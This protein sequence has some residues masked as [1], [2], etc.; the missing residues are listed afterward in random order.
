MATGGVASAL[1]GCTD[2]ATPACHVY[3][4]ADLNASGLSSRVGEWLWSLLLP[5]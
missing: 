1:H 2:H 4:Y 5:P 3:R